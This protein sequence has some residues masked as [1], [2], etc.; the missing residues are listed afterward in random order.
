MTSINGGPPD[1]LAMIKNCQLDKERAHQMINDFN[2]QQRELVNLNAFYIF[3]PF[4]FILL[5]GLW[6]ITI[7]GYLT[8][9]TSL[10]IT[11]FIILFLYVLS[12][13]YRRRAYSVIDDQ[14]NQMH[15]LVNRSKN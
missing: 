10:M 3:F 8:W 4:A 13:A 1:L 7:G 15:E 2:T 11:I 6:L 14:T 9:P 12:V 5:I